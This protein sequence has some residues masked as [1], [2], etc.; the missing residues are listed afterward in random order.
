MSNE[1]IYNFFSNDLVQ[2]ITQEDETND[3]SISRGNI[4][5]KESQ[6]RETAFESK[7][8]KK[9]TRRL[10]KNLMSEKNLSIYRESLK[11]S[12]ILENMNS[13]TITI[14]ELPKIS[15]EN[16]EKF[17]E[18][19]ADKQALSKLC[20]GINAINCNFKCVD[21]NNSLGG[22]SPLTYLIES[23]F[24]MSTKKAREINDKY[25]KLKPYIYNY[26]TINGDG[27]CFYRA[28]MFRYLEI[29][30]LNRKVDLLQNV[31]YDVYKN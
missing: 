2:D 27:N 24:A 8:N 17:K 18:S 10:S 25:N 13:E 6:E 31:A 1:P 9:L 23:S 15:E 3:N 16:Y 26:R 12:G 21:S 28:V 14:R 4:P 5:N 20:D 30:V 11:D 22:I 19:I 29:L 7:L